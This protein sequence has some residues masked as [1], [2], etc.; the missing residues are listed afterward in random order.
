MSNL[1]SVVLMFF[2]FFLYS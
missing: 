1:F 2:C